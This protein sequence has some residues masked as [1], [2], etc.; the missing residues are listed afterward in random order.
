MFTSIKKMLA[1]ELHNKMT[2]NQ[3]YSKV[4]ESQLTIIADTSDVKVM[5]INRQSLE[6]LPDLVKH[7]IEELILMQNFVEMDRPFKNNAELK[8]FLSVHCYWRKFKT[9]TTNAIQM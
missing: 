2:S 3:I 7:K 1:K 6:L 8:K 4:M 5:C 9:E